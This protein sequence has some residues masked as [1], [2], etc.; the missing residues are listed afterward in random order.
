MITHLVPT[1][2]VSESRGVETAWVELGNDRLRAHG[3]V[4]GLMPAP[5]WLDYELDTGPGWTTRRLAVRAASAQGVRELEL[6]NHDGRWTVDGHHRPELDGALDCDLGLSPLTN[7]MPL[8]R[9][10]LHRE[11]GRH[12]FLMAWV[13]VPDLTVHPSRQ[14]YTHLG[15][16]GNEDAA[17]AAATVR[18]ES[19][20]FRADLLVD[21]HDLLVDLHGLVLDY[22]GLARGH[23]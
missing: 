1:W 12:D 19:G 20:G 23:N 14:T 13:R 21:L 2:E 17:G 7:A 18:Y 6:L 11:P 3:R 22:P 8:L 15:P 16:T 9:H 4:A 5:Y 10:R